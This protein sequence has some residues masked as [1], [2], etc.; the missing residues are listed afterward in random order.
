MELLLL[1]PAKFS[2][3]RLDCDCAWDLVLEA[4]LLDAVVVSSDFPV[5]VL[6][7]VTDC[8]GV[9]SFSL[10]VGDAISSM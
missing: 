2:D 1:P 9:A 8:L 5:G 7:V 6:N 3:V 10:R 4:A